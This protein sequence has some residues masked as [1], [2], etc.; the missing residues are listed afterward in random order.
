MGF[1][2]SKTYLKKH[3][4]D[5]E[6]AE[7][8]FDDPYARIIYDPDHS[9]EENR[10]IIIG[11][12]DRNRLLYVSFTARGNVIRIISARKADQSEHKAYEEKYG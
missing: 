4:V 12:S 2:Q 10:E 6:E 3:G 11:Q 1:R 5:F 9:V 7:T 8:V